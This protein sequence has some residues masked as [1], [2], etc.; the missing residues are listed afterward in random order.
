MIIDSHCHLDYFSAE[1]LPQV[2]ARAQQCNVRTMQTIA[3]N[4][5]N[6]DKL[7]DITNKYTGIY[8]SVGIHP[9]E[10]T[11]SPPSQQEI[12]ALTK[13]AKVIG[14]GETGLDYYQKVAPKEWQIKSFLIHI[15]A[16]RFTGLPIIIHARAADTDMRD[17]LKQEMYK[18][19][20]TGLLHCFSSTRSLC[21]QAL[22]L[23]LYIS[24]SGI[25]TFKNARD[26]Q[27]IVRD[28]PLNRLLV[29]TDAPYLAPIPQRGKRNEPAFIYH[30][31]EYI[32]KLK[33]CSIDNVIE[34]TTNN[35]FTLFN[36]AG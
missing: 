17:I 15:H 31:V 23:G 7:F 32:A 1:E 13:H 22:D 2:I 33:Q 5:T 30:T 3:T 8:M 21:E 19:K 10:V 14:I 18:G 26:L 34:H 24:I 28:V 29:E 16:A 11:I 12:V 4:L 25:V 35:F 36:K 9:N 20:F 6:I 27:D